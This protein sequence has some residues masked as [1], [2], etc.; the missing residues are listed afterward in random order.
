MI[1]AARTFAVVLLGAVLAAACGTGAPDHVRIGV[2]VPLTGS[3]AFLG[4]EVANGAGLAVAELNRRGGLLGED[5]EL[6]VVDDA[7]LVDLPGQLADLA[8][9]HRVSVVIG[10]ETPGVLTGP[11]SPLSR[12]DV[13][14]LLPTAFAGDL[15]DADTFVA[16]TVPSARVQAERLGRWLA[17]TREADEVAV[18]V[19]DPVEG[20]AAAADL[21]EGLTAGGVTVTALRQADGEA[22]QLGPSVSRLRREAPSA[23]AVLLW[24]PPP[25]TARATLAVRD[26]GWDVQLAVPASSFVAEYRSLAG[27][28]S[29]GVVLAFPFRR[30][31]FGARLTTWM[32]AY[33]AEHGIGALPGL[34]TL[35][36]DL[37][38]AAVAAYDAVMVAADAVR[39]AD[40]REPAAVAAA[41]GEVVT[42]GILREYDLADREAYTADDLHVARFHHLG[43]VYDADPTLD[44]EAQRRFWEAQVS[45]RFLPEEVLTGPAGALIEALIAERRDAVPDYAPPLPPPGPVARP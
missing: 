11:R 8:E 44:A 16:R 32:L 41:L 15:E 26:L 20:S 36:I 31:W 35:V 22:T 37:P 1:A 19:V 21:R 7:D 34:D 38:V 12:R 25:A 43:V 42:D 40:S 2:L 27:D 23:D 39:A 29:E 6:V 30:E 4:Q 45:A 28:A 5:V 9:R 14:A 17:E 24:G 18:L 10:P 3:R 13:P 33:H